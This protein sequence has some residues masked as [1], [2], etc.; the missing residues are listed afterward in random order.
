L[1]S[2]LSTVGVQS[3]LFIDAKRAVE[4]GLIG[5]GMVLDGEAGKEDGELPS[6]GIVMSPFAD[7]AKA[8]TDTLVLNEVKDGV[9]E[10]GSKATLASGREAS[11]RNANIIGGSSS[12]NTSVELAV[13]GLGK[14]SVH[15]DLDGRKDSDNVVSGD[16]QREGILAE[17]GGLD[18]LMDEDI[19]EAIEAVQ[20]IGEDPKDRADGPWKEYGIRTFQAVFRR[21]NGPSGK[22]MQLEA[23]VNISLEYPVC[24]PLF[25]VRLLSETASVLSLPAAP[26]GV[27]DV[28]EGSVSKAVSRIDHSFNSLRAIEV[29][30]NITIPQHLPVGDRNQTL[31]HQIAALMMLFD[32]YVDT[33][34]GLGQSS[35]GGGTA[36]DELRSDLTDLLRVKVG[37]VRLCRGRE[38]RKPLP[39]VLDNISLEPYIDE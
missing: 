8:A 30:V 32:I 37:N 14:V 24:P 20:L 1:P 38:R 27:L 17:L 4:E 7:A 31:S 13:S 34:L 6:S 3:T 15:V 21:E 16:F 2:S 18:A 9:W 28:A 33:E 26:G 10:S 36:D 19:G 25:Q 39:W 5:S 22:C 35:D 12:N 23:Q 29:E 11:K